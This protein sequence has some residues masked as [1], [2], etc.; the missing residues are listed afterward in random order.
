MDYGL[1]RYDEP[2][3]RPVRRR[4]NYFA[5]TVA[6]LLL[7]GFAFAAWLGSFYIFSQP[8][9]PD[10]YRILQKLHKVEPPKRFELTAAPP[11]EFLSA[12]Q[13]YD[14]YN[15]MGAAEFSKTNAELARNYIRNFQQVRGLIP[16]VVGRYVIEN[17]RELSSSDVFTSGM[18]ALTNSVES[19]E[20][21]MEHLYPSEPPTVPLIKQT[22]TPG[23]EIKLDRAH[24]LSAV[25]HV[26]RFPDGR[27]MLTTVPLLYGTYTVMRGTGTFSLEPPLSLNL[28]AGWPL[29]KEQSRLRA[30]MHYTQFKQSHGQPQA[31]AQ[32]AV[33]GLVPGGTP[34]PPENQ[35]V[36]V[37]SAKA[38][39]PPPIVQVQ[40][41]KNGKPMP[42]PKG[43]SAKGKPTPKTSAAPS[44]IAQ[45]STSPAP[46]PPAPIAQNSPPPA[47]P[48]KS[49]PPPAPPQQVAKAPTPGAS[50]HAP[51]IAMARPGENPAAPQASQP[52][53]SDVGT[54][55]STT[56][57][58]SWKTFPAGKMPLGRLIAATDLKEIADK[59]TGGERLYLKG[60][61]VVNFSDANR[62]VLRPRGK[63]TDSVLHFG[64]APTR[65]IVEF[66]AGHPPPAQGSTV[67]RDES[68]PLEITEVRK[69]ED[70]QLNVF[71][72]EIMQ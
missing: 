42:T 4:I 51:E 52:P 43:K 70:G 8:E 55:A 10:S 48:Q 45:G 56:G 28:E 5:W 72:R 59:G 32:V 35:L 16:Y 18:V 49:Q 26:E 44:A 3:S 11:G 57:G 19:P 53:P 61:F 34:P 29:F 69:Q 67:S 6:I 71:A 22:L 40:K 25:I 14:R 17:A 15:A 38:V 68:R 9:R 37:E 23:L 64:A 1:Y 62:A 30:E 7:T 39:T 12:K 50:P 27:I 47:A 58:G 65:I 31:Q 21:L 33:P 20:L 24:D 46:A 41:G 60:Q 66:P 13:L 2:Y 54:L 36:R 63:L